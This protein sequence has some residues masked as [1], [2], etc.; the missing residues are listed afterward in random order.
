MGSIITALQ[1]CSNAGGVSPGL[2]REST[3]DEVLQVEPG[4]DGEASRRRELDI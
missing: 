2:F 1:A 4:E 3:F